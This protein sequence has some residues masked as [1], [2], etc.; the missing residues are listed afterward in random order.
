LFRLHRVLRRHGAGAVGGARR[1]SRAS[2]KREDVGA[3]RTVDAN[4]YGGAKMWPT[5]YSKV[6][7]TLATWVA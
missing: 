4:V 7:D 2:S 6:G 5:T 1:A 3:A